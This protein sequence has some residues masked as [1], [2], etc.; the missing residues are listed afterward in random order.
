[1]NI[2]TIFA[3]TIILTSTN[4]FGDW[5]TNQY[6]FNTQYDTD[7]Y[8]QDERIRTIERERSAERFQKQMDDMNRQREL[9]H[10][11]TQDLWKKFNGGN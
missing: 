3:V 6:K 5:N 11:R 1:M 2:K 9:Q 7:R 10:Q 4:T 8:Y